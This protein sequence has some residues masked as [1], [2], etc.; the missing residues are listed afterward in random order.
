MTAIA[1]APGLVGGGQSG[2]RALEHNLASRIAPMLARSTVTVLVFVGLG[3]L[4]AARPDSPG[5]SAMFRGNLGHTGVY[6]GPGVPALHGPK[7]TFATKGQIYSSPAVVDGV[8]YVGSTD[9]AVYAIDAATGTEKWKVVTKGRVVSS[10]AVA[11][12][13]VYIESYDG[14]LY[15][16]DAVTGQV[17][18]TFATGGEHRFMARHIHGLEPANELMPDP[19]DFYLSSPAV[20]SGRVYF[21]SGDG[22]IY[23]IDVASGA[24]KWKVSTG[25]VVHSSPAVADGVVFIGGWDTYLHALD[26]VT[27]HE[28]WRFK[29]GEDEAI[30]NQ[31]GIQ[32]SPVVSDGLVYIG[33]RDSRLYALDVKTG[34]QMWAF[35]NKGSWVIGSPAVTQGTV[36]FATSDSALFQAVDAKTGAL[37]FSV[38]FKWPMF[39]SPAVAGTTAYIGSHEGKLLAIDLTTH[40]LAWAFV[41]D[42]A[43]TEGPAL[44]RPDGT[45][46]YGA[47][48]HSMFY[49]DV[50]AGIQKMFSVGAILSSPVV[51]GDTV[52]VGS[53]NGLLY[54][55]H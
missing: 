17:R 43:R 28:L 21:G 42:S 29:T 32:S 47:A 54:A 24:L 53:A 18:W 31:T 39:S 25:N 22:N 36:Y 15:A 23:A 6:A 44:S 14:L 26:A 19:F 45:P 30:H 52:Y 48:M 3:G 50:V 5:E 35:D 9:G 37:R 11:E 41:T 38:A 40:Q 16:I 20:S 2:V 55:L 51:V 13:T 1:T 33:C 8:V 4:L 10:P 49:D 7:W 12:G 46:N 34:Q 27:G